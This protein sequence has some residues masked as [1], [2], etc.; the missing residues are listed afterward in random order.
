MIRLDLL[1]ELFPSIQYTNLINRNHTA[2]E[3]CMKRQ[4][5]RILGKQLIIMKEDPYEGYIFCLTSLFRFYC[6]SVII[7]A[8]EF[9]TFRLQE[10]FSKPSSAFMV[11]R[12]KAKAILVISFCSANEDM[13]RIPFRG[14]GIKSS[15]QKRIN[16]F[17]VIC[18]LWQHCIIMKL[19][20]ALF[21]ACQL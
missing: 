16:Y 6:L 15:A 1:Q 8:Y 11:V 18:G 7:S 2:S 20:K 14:S 4:K 13:C 5:Q 10:V 3:I 9:I 17:A 12:L 21:R 19:S